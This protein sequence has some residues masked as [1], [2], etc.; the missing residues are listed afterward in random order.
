[1]DGFTVSFGQV[2]QNG[3]PRRSVEFP[4]LLSHEFYPAG[5][6]VHLA[7]IYLDLCSNSPLKTRPPHAGHL[8]SAKGLL[9]LSL[10]LE[11]T[12]AQ[13]SDVLRMFEASKLKDLH[14]TLEEGPDG[15]WPVHSWGIQVKWTRLRTWAASSNRPNIARACIACQCRRG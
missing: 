15:L 10:S 6:A 11:V 5:S 12:R 8:L 2:V 4:Y 1:M 13:F 14:F 9:S 7:G 3:P